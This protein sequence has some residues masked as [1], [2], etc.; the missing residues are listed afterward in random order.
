MGLSVRCIIWKKNQKVQ[1][2]LISYDFYSFFFYQF[3]YMAYNLRKVIGK[4][5][6]QALTKAQDVIGESK[7]T[8]SRIKR[9]SDDHHI[10]CNVPQYHNY[11]TRRGPNWLQMIPTRRFIFITAVSWYPYRKMGNCFTWCV[12]WSIGK[13]R[14]FLRAQDGVL[15]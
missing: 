8:P 1:N 14:V 12:H 9:L 11:I 5:Q 4:G 3:V 6:I 10:L 15:M 7:Y 13:I 2:L